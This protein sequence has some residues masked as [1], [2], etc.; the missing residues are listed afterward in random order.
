MSQPDLD[1]VIVGAGF[2]GIFALHRLRQLGFTARVIERASDVGGTWFW[3][4]YPGARCEVQSMSYS[5]SFDEDLEQEWR[6]PHR[7]AYQADILRYAAYV[8]ERFDLRRDMVFATTV[9]SARYDEGAC[10]WTVETD[11][12]EAVSARFLILATGCLS[13]PNWPGFEGLNRFEGQVIHTAYWPHEGVDF[14]GQRVGVIG[15]GA[16]GVQTIPQVAKE[17]AHLTVFQRSANFAVPARNTPMSESYEAD[18]KSRY[19]ELREAARASLSADFWEGGEV[20]MAELS[21]KAQE[22]RLEQM[23][24][25]GGFALQYGFSDL[26]TDRVSND[27]AAEFVRGKIRET[28]ADADTARVLS[29]QNHPLGTKR[30]CVDDGYFET[31]NRENVDLV[32]LRSTPI[33]KVVSDGIVTGGTHHALDALILATGFDAFTGAVGRIDIAGLSGQRLKPLWDHSAD[34]Y[35]GLAVV[36]FP[37]MFTVTGPGSPSVFT[38]MMVAI[39]QHVH[40]ISDC[41]GYMRQHGHRE[42]AALPEAQAK[43]CRRVQKLA[44]RTLYGQAQ[45]WYKG[46]NIDG[47]S[48]TFLAF[49]GGQGPYK[50]ICDRVA[51]REYDGFSFRA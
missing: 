17:A 51:E 50:A 1:V 43:W 5:Y 33:E 23:W 30:L 2:S 48:D 42:I 7:Y 26:L 34:S 39:E 18:I 36:G 10:L 40:W 46:A 9:T 28:V 44:A 27:V 19:P 11:P 25:Q 45:S 24:V 4:R 41:L 16:S 38:N 12:G 13:Q 31:F 47:K 14:T 8:V 20:A 15:T 22:A 35:L 3:N 32:D 29:S 21:P 49:V 37:N 6:W